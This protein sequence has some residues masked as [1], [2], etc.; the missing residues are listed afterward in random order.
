MEE[1]AGHGLDPGVIDMPGDGRDGDFGT[2][3]REDE[4]PA[5]ALPDRNRRPDR[6]W[7]SCTSQG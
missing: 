1:C 5:A 7:S 6:D 3:G 2:V 4:F